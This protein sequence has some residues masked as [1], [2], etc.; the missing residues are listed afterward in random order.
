MTRGLD[1]GTCHIGHVGGVSE[2]GTV[3]KSHG[4]GRSSDGPGQ[5]IQ[6]VGYD[7]TVRVWG[8]SIV[9]GPFWPSHPSLIFQLP[10]GKKV[11]EV[12]ASHP[13]SRVA[14]VGT[15]GALELCVSVYGQRRPSR[16]QE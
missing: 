6:E 16:T 11:T 7:R 4:V 5:D 9:F 13:V 8:T 14:S 15:G 3:E 12:P 1:I 2:N 10:D